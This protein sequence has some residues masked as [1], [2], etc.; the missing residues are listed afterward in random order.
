METLETSGNLVKMLFGIIII[1]LIFNF[2]LN[3]IWDIL[4]FLQLIY[5][6]IF[7][8]LRLPLNVVTGLQ[9]M[10]TYNF[11]FL[12]N[13]P[14]ITFKFIKFDLPLDLIEVPFTK[15]DDGIQGLF[16]L[17]AGE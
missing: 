2:L 3:M 15:Y 8:N 10:K 4:D 13:L 16:I 17:T 1:P 7:L 9:L 11:D 14:A 6:F 5:Y 12:P